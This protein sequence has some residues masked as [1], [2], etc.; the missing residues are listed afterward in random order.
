MPNPIKTYSV[1]EETTIYIP[2]CM[3]NNVS[4][5]NAEKRIKLTINALEKACDENYLDHDL[6]NM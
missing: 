2:L 5:P 4:V 1:N 6:S 3:K